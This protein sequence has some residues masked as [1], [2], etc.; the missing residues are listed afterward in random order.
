MVPFLTRVVATWPRSRPCSG[1][2]L[3][4]IVRCSVRGGVAL[5]RFVA[6]AVIGRFGTPNL[7][8]RDDAVARRL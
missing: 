1:F 6:T 3:F 7:R 4:A 2:I 8:V 5:L